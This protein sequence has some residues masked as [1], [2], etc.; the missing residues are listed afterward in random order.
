MSAP[1][2]PAEQDPAVGAEPDH[3]PPQR[4]Q[5]E[6]AVLAALA[7]YVAGSAA[8]TGA[9]T[10]AALIALLARVGVRRRAA[11]AVLQLNLA[12]GVTVSGFGLGDGAAARRVAAD[13][14]MWRAAYLLNAGRR[15]D[16]ALALPQR[17]D[18][19]GLTPFDRAL[20]D[21]RRFIDQHTAAAA[22]RAAVGAQVDR[23]AAEHG[24]LLGWHTDPTSK[25]TPACAAMH[26]TNFYAAYP[27]P[28]GYPGAVHP[29]CRCTAGRP[30]PRGRVVQPPGVSM[31]PP[32]LVALANTPATAVELARY[33]RTQ[34][35]VARYKKPIGSLIT[36]KGG[37]HTTPGATTAKGRRSRAMPTHVRVQ[38]AIDRRREQT[39]RARTAT[40]R[41]IRM[42]QR[43]AEKALRDVPTPMLYAIRRE[44]RAATPPEWAVARV[45]DEHAKRRDWV[46][47]ELARRAGERV[48]AMDDVRL[49]AATQRALER[50][51]MSEAEPYL[52]EMDRRQVAEQAREA[53][54]VRDREARQARADARERE[55]AAMFDRLMSAGVSEEEAV[56][57]AYGIPVERQRRTALL[58]ELHA[59][60]YKGGLREA[61]RAEYEADIRA[62]Y[63]TAEDATRGH[64]LTREGEAK[65]L[66]PEALFTGPESRAR[67]YA[68]PELLEWWDEHGRLTFDEYLAERLDPANARRLRAAR[69]DFLT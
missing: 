35:G 10:V 25:V 22:R 38:R 24:L 57:D 53:K 66:D 34:A 43:Q 60:G 67:R 21:E 1:L 8:V 17:A 37:H 20:L 4:S 61:A 55:Q 9:V 48:R 26:G 30:H 40:D 39:D 59:N 49:G 23:A 15:L 46:N 41:L 11:R 13:E 62:R 33:V 29:R 19:Q 5:L 36:D 63:R 14:P 47:A 64:M 28:V 3:A 68:S 56:A 51:R 31:A 2:L 54:R 50:G 16:R 12:I 58:G 69:G 7:A 45:R 18:E 32:A 65:G 6:L 27:P 44:Q 52:R 42:K